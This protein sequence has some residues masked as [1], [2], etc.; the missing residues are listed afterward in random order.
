MKKKK[1][2]YE[3]CRWFESCK[4]HLYV[5]KLHR[6]SIVGHLSVAFNDIS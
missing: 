1:S 2:V 3:M 5:V 4:N 6:K